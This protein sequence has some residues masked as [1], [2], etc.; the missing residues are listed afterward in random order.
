MYLDALSDLGNY[1]RQHPFLRKPARG[2]IDLA[3]LPAALEMLAHGLERSV[4]Q[5]SDDVHP[6]SIAETSAGS[7]KGTRALW[8][9]RTA[10]RFV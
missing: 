1:H 3:Q 6:A 8:L 7:F 10:L 4:S 2:H 5:H 9:C